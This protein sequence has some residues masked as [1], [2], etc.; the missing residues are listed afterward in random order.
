MSSAIPYDPYDDIDNNPFAEPDENSGSNRDRL[1]HSIEG[2]RDNIVENGSNM[3]P[4]GEINEIQ[5]S[6]LDQELEHG[7]KSNTHALGLEQLLPERM[8]TKYQLVVQVTGLE[9]A[10]SLHNKKENPSVKFDCNT[11]LPTFRKKSHRNLKKTYTEFY[12]LFKYLNAATPET[13]VPAL[14]KPSTSYGINNQEDVVKTISNFQVWFNRVCSDPLLI[15]SEE[16]AFFIESDFNTYTPIGKYYNVSGLKRKTLKQLTPPYDEVLTLAEFRPLV[17]SIYHTSQDIQAKLLK[18]CTVRRELSQD[19]NSFGHSFQSISLDI[20]GL[21]QKFGKV[22]TAIGDI[23]SIVSN[24]DMA[25]LYDAL[26]FIERDSYIIKE[27]LT[28]RHFLMRELLQAQQ[29]SKQKQENARRLR[30]KREMNPLKVDESIRQLKETTKHEHELTIKLKRTTANMLIERERWLNYLE[31]ML[32]RAIKE[33]VLRKIEY[34]RKKLSLLERVR[35]AV[36]TADGKGGLS[37]LGR[38]L[39]I[40]SSLAASQSFSG[41]SWTGDKNRQSHLSGGVVTTEFDNAVF[42][43]EAPTQT[44]QITPDVLSARQAASMLGDS[45]F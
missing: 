6:S 18:M 41:D 22:V 19:I 38:S 24:L 15:R 21:Y 2:E 35:L 45:S 7:K 8:N 12:K 3:L 1:P 5:E 40:A 14:P 43:K 44:E 10:G 17:K 32:A 42:S 16:I 26:E 4:A 39:P 27:S 31:Q 37:R 34:D 36:R 23:D 33:F 13:F 9:R 25:T 29:N 30:A 28:N 20:S 11:N